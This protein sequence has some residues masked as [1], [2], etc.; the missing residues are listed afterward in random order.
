[1]NL[2]Y[3]CF[4]QRDIFGN[5]GKALLKHFQQKCGENSGTPL[6]NLTAGT[7]KKWRFEF[8]KWFFLF[9]VVG[10]FR[11]HLDF[12]GWNMDVSENSGS[13]KSSILIGFSIINHPFWGTQNFWKHPYVHL[14]RIP[15]IGRLRSITD[16]PPSASQ[17][18]C[19]VHAL[20]ARQNTTPD[21]ADF[22]LLMEEIRLTTWDV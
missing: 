15:S 8:G 16:V 7:P 14:K 6:K 22:I 13:P 12:Q 1:M 20:G 3:K 4:G 19:S 5:C 10:I 2:S 11:F 17:V 21:E 9:Q 18:D